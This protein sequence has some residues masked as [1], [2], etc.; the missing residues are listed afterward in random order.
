MAGIKWATQTIPWEL[1]LSPSSIAPLS[2][3]LPVPVLPDPHCL[4]P[5]SITNTITP[6]SNQ[7]GAI[8]TATH[9]QLHCI[10]YLLPSL[11]RA[12]IGFLYLRPDKLTF[13]KPTQKVKSSLHVQCKVNASIWSG[14]SGYGTCGGWCLK[15]LVHF[16]VIHEIEE[17]SNIPCM[18]FSILLFCSCLHHLQPS[19]SEVTLWQGAMFSFNATGNSS[20][21]SWPKQQKFNFVRQYWL[22]VSVP[23][24]QYIMMKDYSWSVIG[25]VQGNLKLIQHV[26]YCDKGLW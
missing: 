8:T 26:M 6:T 21:V 3:W 10:H 9:I 1:H 14:C 13:C 25:C 5:P 2:A 22:L 20:D 18:N 4:D 23:D 11:P 7:L 24:T 12:T 19:C 15:G 17:S 16:V